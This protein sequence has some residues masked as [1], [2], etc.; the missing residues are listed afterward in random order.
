M[1]QR[2]SGYPG[3]YCRLPGMVCSV[4]ISMGGIRY[5][6]YTQYLVYLF[7]PSAF[8]AS[9]V[10][11]WN[12]WKLVLP[13]RS[14]TSRS[15]ASLLARCAAALSLAHLVP[16]LVTDQHQLIYGL[17]GYLQARAPPQGAEESGVIQYYYGLALGQ[18]LSGL[19]EQFIDI[20]GTQVSVVL[21]IRFTY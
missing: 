21:F 10:N 17:L 4:V 19:L 16:S 18:A 15:P 14:D 11:M 3:W 5:F 1:S 6:C 13:Q 9:T 2:Y 20:S 12:D 8:Y 7:F